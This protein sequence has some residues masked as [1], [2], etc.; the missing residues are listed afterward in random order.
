M[1]DDLRER[2]GSEGDDTRRILE[3]LDFEIEQL[4]TEQQGLG[5]TTWAALA[6]ISGALWLLVDQIKSASSLINVIH[7]Y[8]ICALTVLIFS[9]VH[10]IFRPMRADGRRG[11]ERPM[12]LVLEANADSLAV[13]LAIVE[14][15]GLCLIALY[16]WPEVSLPVRVLTA[17]LSASFA[18]VGV[19]ALVATLFNVPV[20]S[21]GGSRSTPS[22]LILPLCIVLWAWLFAEYAWTLLADQ[23][24]TVA[25][26]RA[27]GLIEGLVVLLGMLAWALKKP[28]LL[29]P[30]IGLRRDIAFKRIDPARAERQAEILILG[31]KVEDALQRNVERLSQILRDQRDEL[32]T[33][34]HESEQRASTQDGLRRG[35]DFATWWAPT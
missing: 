10:S 18:L 14:M 7:V 33:I 29:Q 16:L 35:N 23:R 32:R 4:R 21:T 11:H 25:D 34:L 17:I 30:L 8:F 12:Q 15:V 6:G 24:V 26:Y 1:T 22:L 3:A 20:P 31:M 27:G 13:L 19:L 5:W 28:L 2:G 9:C